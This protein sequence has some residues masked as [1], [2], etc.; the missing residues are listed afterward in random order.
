[1]A[2]T[3]QAIRITFLQLILIGIIILG[4]LVFFAK[5][6][7]ILTE[8]EQAVV[9]RFGEIVSIEQEAGIKFKIPVI[10]VITKYSKKILSWDGDARRVPTLE[11]QFIWVDPTARWRIS[12]PQKFYASI[13]TME[14][15]FSRLDDL[16]E[17]AVRTTIAQNNLVESVRNTNNI[18][19]AQTKQDD[20]F[21][22]EGE[23][24]SENTAT[25]ITS[26][27]TSLVSQREEQAI[28]RKGR[29]SLSEEMLEAVQTSTPAFGIEIIDIII[30]QI[31]YSDDLTESVYN[32]MISERKQKAQ[33]YRSFG[34][35]RKKQLLGQ[36]ENE[37]KSILSKA[38]AESE[39]VKGKA[40]ATAA[41]VYSD[42]YQ[43]NESFFQFW[44]A[45]ES[46]K[47]SVPSMDKVLSTDLDYFNYL[48][49]SQGR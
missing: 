18:L 1:M 23:S 2:N 41:R 32:R 6:I 12:D 27:I 16:I 48:Y 34:E 42:A 17:S 14:Q 26:E 20:A 45:M 8:G 7:Y 19:D 11:K 4:V 30:K 39:T 5:P 9:T 15:A 46:Y 21:L 36:L 33:I 38:Y 3:Q 31:R 40:D 49:D 37:K 10:E 43:Q 13:N 28:I 29:R 35:G 24:E 44:R 22:P 25:T 47:R